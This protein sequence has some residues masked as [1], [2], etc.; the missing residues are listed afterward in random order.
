MNLPIIVAGECIVLFCV[1]LQFIIVLHMLHID[2]VQVNSF[3]RC[4]CAPVF[5]VN[6]VYD[7]TCHLGIL[8]VLWVTVLMSV[9]TYELVYCASDKLKDNLIE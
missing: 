2:S 1:V 6:I 4:V 3:L 8:Y 5:V 9:G 7:C